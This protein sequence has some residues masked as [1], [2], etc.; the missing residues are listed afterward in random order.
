MYVYIY[1]NIYIYMCKLYWAHVPNHLNLNPSTAGYV[2]LKNQG[3]TCYMNSL[4]HALF[5]VPALQRAV[6]LVSN[7]NLGY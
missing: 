3:A 7:L 2:G 4:L 1:I 5:H 6:Y